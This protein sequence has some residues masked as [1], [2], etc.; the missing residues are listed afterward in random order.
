MTISLTTGNDTLK[1]DLTLKGVINASKSFV[2]LTNQVIDGGAGTDHFVYNDVFPSQYFQLSVLSDGGIQLVATASSASG[3]S[4]SVVS[5]TLKNFERLEFSNTTLSL[6]PSSGVHVLNG[7]AG[8]NSLKS[9]AGADYLFGEAG[10]DTLDGGAGIDSMSGGTGNDIYVVDNKSDVV[11]ENASSGTDLVD[12]SIATSGGTYTLPA[13]VENGTLTNTVA[14]TLTGNTLANALM[15]NAAADTLNGGDGNDTLNGGAGADKLVGG[16]GNDVY[17]VDDAG[18]VVT[19]A[20]ASGTDLVKVSI[21]TADLTYAL[22]ANVENATLIN[23]VAFNLTGNGLGNVLT[24]NAAANV[25]DGKG[26]ADTL[27]GGGGADVFLFS[28]APGTGNVDTVMDFTTGG[29][30]HI[31]LQQSVFTAL[32]D[33]PAAAGT[34]L[35]PAEF[36]AAA[37]AQT[38]TEHL[39][40]DASTGKLFYDPT[41][42]DN[43]TTDRVQIALIGTSTTHPTL[44]ASDFLVV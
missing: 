25:L 33:I 6:V 20:S 8:N 37:S 7:N 11:T 12:V 14:F 22:A 42:S 36:R 5:V 38:S 44:E 23:A 19:E 43:G 16:A 4:S 32:T 15:G 21:T 35:D 24:G 1:T 2:D 39:L 40:Y 3:G 26:G 29:V 34:P 41:G 18:D 9:L 10:N 13:N 17:F 30:D 27:K 28:T 31:A